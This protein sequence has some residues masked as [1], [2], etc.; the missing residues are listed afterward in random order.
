MAQ[1][2]VPHIDSLSNTG[3]IRSNATSAASE[4]GGINVPDGL[5][6]DPSADMDTGALGNTLPDH[7]DDA[8]F[9]DTTKR[10]WFGLPGALVVFAA[11]RNLSE[12]DASWD[13]SSF[14]R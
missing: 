6:M 5:A 1:H 13:D 2:E 4:V 10:R 12:Q 8:T 14:G 7:Y 11:T 3:A 9:V